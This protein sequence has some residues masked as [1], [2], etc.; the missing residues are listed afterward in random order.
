MDFDSKLQITNHR[1]YSEPEGTKTAYYHTNNSSRQKKN[2]HINN[3]GRLMRHRS[4]QLRRDKQLV[5]CVSAEKCVKMQRAPK[6][7][8]K[9]NVQQ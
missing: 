5:K 2:P 9:L 1:A 6:M 8:E 4:K 3:E 7:V